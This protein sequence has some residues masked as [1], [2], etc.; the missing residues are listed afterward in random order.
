MEGVRVQY[1]SS[2]ASYEL[3]FLEDEDMGAYYI[4]FT[5]YTFLEQ[6]QGYA[7]DL[8]ER[9]RL[10]YF[11]DRY[12]VSSSEIVDSCPEQKQ[13][14]KAYHC[15]GKIVYL[16]QDARLVAGKEYLFAVT[17]VKNGKEAKIMSFEKSKVSPTS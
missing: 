4:Y 12:M 9:V 7:I 17:S 6:S 3:T 8:Q 15:D 5:D 11:W 16:L 2:L 14:M 10:D 1:D 13:P